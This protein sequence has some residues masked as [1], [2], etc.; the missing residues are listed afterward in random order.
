MPLRNVYISSTASDLGEY[1][2][3]ARDA[4]LQMGMHPIMMEDFASGSKSPVERSYEELL[5]ADIY[6]GILAYRYG[7]IPE[8]YE[9][10][11]I[12]IEYE[13][14]RERGIPCLMF[15]ASQDWQ[16][17]LR[18]MPTDSSE[19][20]K[21]E[22]FK[23]RIL[24]GH[25]VSFFRSVD[26]FR[27]KLV[28]ALSKLL[29]DQSVHV[30]GDVENQVVSTIGEEIIEQ[31][32]VRAL[33]LYD[34][35]R[36]LDKNEHGADDP[37]VICIKPIFGAPSK[38]RQFQCDLFMIM[39]FRKELDEIYEQ[40]IKTV[41]SELNLTIKRGKDFHSPQGEV[42]KEVWHAIN[43]CRLVIVECTEV[44]GQING[45]VYYELGIAD[46]IGKPAILI[47]Q[48]MEK[49]PFDVKHRRFI[50]YDNTITGGK[51][52]HDELK[53]AILRILNDLDDNFPS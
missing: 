45:N 22:R 14:A 2:D 36:Q 11:M 31:A 35:K 4:V 17:G 12:E 39:P 29:T 8:G 1:R 48:D 46:A 43:A 37:D 21:I 7:Y 34:A 28:V 16:P 13:W 32:I 30:L 18:G 50:P 6:V 44:E 51:E 25:V 10:S 15:L 38:K 19:Y 53:T 23:Q 42:M 3:S 26:D 52:L 49:I 33:E 27:A 5:K 20:E 24:T 9:I 47:A 40:T 41:A